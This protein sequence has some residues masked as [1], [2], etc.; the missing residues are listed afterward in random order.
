MSSRGM[1]I[2]WLG[3]GTNIGDRLSHIES[4]IERLIPVLENISRAGLYDTAP[5]DFLDQADFL[6]TVV[7]GETD[8]S[9]LELLYVLHEVES[10]G[11][12]D[13]AKLP[14]TPL[15][16]PRTI[17]I[18]I[19]LYDNICSTFTGDDGGSLTIPHISM[20]QRL[21]VLKPLLDLDSEM[22]DPTDGVLWRYKASQIGDQRVKLYK[23]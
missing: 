17:D 9:P 4:A 2:V 11:G 20:H 21:F 15:K 13:R 1:S 14:G 5:R 12:R 23:R 10:K 6:N 22:K 7:R 8:L 18:D 16:G 19:L 3:L